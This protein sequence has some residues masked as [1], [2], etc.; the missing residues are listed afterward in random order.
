MVGVQSGGE[1]RRS[2]VRYDLRSITADFRHRACDVMDISEH[3]LRL[4]IAGDVPPTGAEIEVSLNVQLMGRTARMVVH[5]NVVRAGGD[6]FALHYN[7]PSSTWPKILKF[8]DRKERGAG[9]APN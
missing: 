3:G 9:G 4:A 7:A 8:L 1:Q 2:E 6:Q 5:G